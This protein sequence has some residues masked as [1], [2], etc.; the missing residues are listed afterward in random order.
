MYKQQL[1][2]P[3]IIIIFILIVSSCANYK[4]H[5]AD[6]TANEQALNTS[7]DLP[8]SH[9]IYLIG[10]AGKAGDSS[11]NAATKTLKRH[12]Q[13]ANKNSTVI[14]LGDN[15]YPDGL[16]QKSKEEERAEA[17]KHLDAQLDALEGYVG[18]PIFIPGNHDWYKYG[19]KGIRRQEK[20]I[21]K[22]LNKN[23][24][25][26]DDWENYFLPDDGCP[27]PEII[28]LT[29]DLVV[30]AVD[31]EWWLED[32]SNEPSINSG[33][34]IKTRAEFA[35][36]VEDAIKD[37][38]HKNIVF[39]THHP[40][41]SY[42]SHGGRY[43]L[44]NHI[45]PLTTFSKNF[46]LPLPVLGSLLMAI[47]SSGL[48]KQDI[49]NKINKAQIKAFEKPVE[50]HG[51]YIF[52]SG[53]DHNQQYIQDNGQ[54]FI[55]SGAGSKENPVAKGENLL[56]GYGRHG[57]SRID[58][59][60]DGSAWVEFWITDENSRDGKRIF[61]SKMKNALPKPSKEP[62]KADFSIYESEVA[63]VKTHPITTPIK[64]KSNF[65]AKVL[66]EHHIDVYL[67]EY[68]F[69]TLNLSTFQGGL[70]VIKKGGG[71]QTNSLRLVNPNGK[72]YVM[73][74][75]TKD[76]KAI[77]YPFNE[78]EWVEYLFK[79]NYLGT[80]PFAPLVVTKLADAVN[81]YHANPEIY[82]VPKQPALDHFNDG[83]GDEVYL[84][85]ER[86]SK[87]RKKLDSF[88]NAEKFI[89]TYDLTEKR[90]KNYKHRV[91]QQWVVRSRLFD[92][93][94]GDFDRHDDQWRW[95][96]VDNNNSYK[97]YRPIPRD[98]DQAFGKYD[99]S[100][101]KL[102]SPYNA[103][104]RQLADYEEDYRSYRWAT[105]NTRF[106]D[107]DFMNELSLEDWLKEADYIQK[108]LTD[109]KIE[110]AFKAFPPK[111]QEI[112]SKDLIS[113]LKRKRA[114]LPEI[115]KGIYLQ[116]S[117]IVSV[118]GTQKKEYFEIK[119]LDAENT[120]INIY[121]RGKNDNKKERVYHRIVKTYETE[122]VH[123]YGLDGDDIYKVTGEATDGVLVRLIGGLGEDEFIDE[124][125]VSGLS[126]KTKI[127]D[128]KTGNKLSIGQEAKDLTSNDA[129]KNFYNRL[130]NQYD[131]NLFLPF[132]LL[133]FNADDGFL[134]GFSGTYQVHGFKKVPYSQ[135]HKFGINYTFLNNGLIFNYQGE[136]IE[137]VGSW[138]FL[139]NG[140]FRNNRFTLNFFGIGNDS[141]RLIDD[142]QFYRI[143]QRK[144]FGE[145]GLQ[146]RFANDIGRLSIRPS[147]FSLEIEDSNDRFIDGDN[148]G[149]SVEDFE[150]RTYG[151]IAANL[152]AKS[153]DNNIS[154]K[155]GFQSNIHAGYTINFTGSERRF[156][157][158]GVDLTIYKSLDPKKRIVV[159]SR[160]GGDFITGNYDF[161]FAPTLGQQEN[162]RGLLRN[163]FRGESVFFHTTD[164]RVG[165]NRVKNS[166]L[167]FSFGITASFDY[168]RVW[169][170]EE[171]SD[172]WHQSYG[173]SIWFVPLNL[174]LISIHYNRSTD[175]NRI[176]VKL[177]HHF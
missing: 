163:R 119:R 98:R 37:H 148:T 15:I 103:L 12:L 107:H 146:K 149:L 77:P 133:G 30:I 99:G 70:S 93:L 39:A 63:H 145:I 13:R 137:T 139:L 143:N 154:P 165:L 45:F 44:K 157:T 114:K 19:V 41:R 9:S 72:E 115:A 173:G 33:C 14:F 125:T 130:G 56:F 28:E 80:H 82:F 96:V 81:V 18:R 129:N 79:D 87:N 74:S 6:I 1:H 89:S 16:P 113:A 116:I 172:T 42:G 76:L 34:E 123:L 4:L 140:I 152:N 161:F 67:E 102:L 58:F 24:E 155:D 122:E 54:H 160:L 159:A 27:G 21:E 171:L 73:R 104:L 31:S 40:L 43:P 109:E 7:V 168:G 10:D 95:A 135:Q 35:D 97:T 121:E 147:V 48:S 65:N 167:P 127:Y 132:P 47:R 131:E 25:D 108:N 84:V 126:K 50:A 90:E 169:Q 117:K 124:S 177:G 36:L 170:P 51:E 120:E 32:W 136:F 59:Y 141:E 75:L 156:A 26:E 91:D 134:I 64:P 164:L 105:Y 11:L 150:A 92:L 101:V 88:G 8:I 86:A 49:A 55:I 153:V 110:L 17:E 83:F 174:A 78:L 23:I 142:R 52:V 158:F 118:H 60:E 128:K 175:D 69:P 62:I 3:F 46:Y 162:I 112:S 144:I 2:K 5:I 66:G 29:D 57:F 22:A 71:K 68:D 85:E 138:D 166:G 111:V 106:F 38:K 176:L 151:K 20:Y 94:I 53:H 100:I 61:R